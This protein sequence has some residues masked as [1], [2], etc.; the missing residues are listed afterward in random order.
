MFDE[1]YNSNHVTSDTSLLETR[2][3]DIRAYEFQIDGHDPKSRLEFTKFMVMA[4]GVGYSQAVESIVIPG[5]SEAGPQSFI[6]V[7]LKRSAVMN[8]ATQPAPPARRRS[9]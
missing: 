5:A 3:V 9:T 2:N 7:Y 1:R 8:G 6:Q 4:V